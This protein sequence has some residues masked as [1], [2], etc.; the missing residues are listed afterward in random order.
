MPALVSQHD[1][2]RRPAGREH[3][4]GGLVDAAFDLLPPAVEAAERT[5]QLDRAACVARQEQ[6]RR[7]LDLAHAPGSVDARSERIADGARGHG[8]LLHGAFGH[9]GC[10][11]DALRIFQRL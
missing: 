5:R 2:L 9:Q 3:G 11:A 10:D 1:C 8:P 6:L 7:D 4:D